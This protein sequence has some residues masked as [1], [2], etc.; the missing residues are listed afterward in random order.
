ML[1]LVIVIIA[2]GWAGFAITWGRDRV[3]STT[4]GG[5][6]PDPYATHQSSLF[7]VP[8]TEEMARTRRQQVFAGLVVAAVLTYVMTRLWSVMWGVHLL[9]DVALI[10][11]AV[12]WYLRSANGSLSV[13]GVAG[14]AGFNQPVTYDSID[15][16]APVATSQPPVSPAPVANGWVGSNVSSVLSSVPRVPLVAAGDEPDFGLPER[17]FGG[18]ATT[19]RFAPVMEDERVAMRPGPVA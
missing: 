2:L 3:R 18:L 4:G 10:V 7:D 6:M 5:L 16:A 8:R 11:F 14:P 1:L 15:D 19:G 17:R 9:V 13:L 12:A